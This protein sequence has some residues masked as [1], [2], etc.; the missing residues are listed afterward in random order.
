MRIQCPPHTRLQD[1]LLSKNIHILTACGG[2]G[3]CGKCRVIAP[4]ARINTMD[5]IWF[6]QD[7]LQQGYRLGCQVFAKDGPLEV[8]LS[9]IHI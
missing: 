9:L 3:N 1:Y 8:E 6:T 7:E 5:R 4:E 2:R